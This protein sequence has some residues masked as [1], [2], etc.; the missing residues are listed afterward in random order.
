MAG[1]FDALKK[2]KYENKYAAKAYSQEGE[3]LVLLRMHYKIT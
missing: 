1:I 2:K 3:D